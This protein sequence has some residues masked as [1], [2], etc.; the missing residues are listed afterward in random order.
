M[1][2]KLALDR[3]DVKVRSQACILYSQT[4]DAIHID[5]KHRPGH[6]Q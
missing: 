3:L 4:F 1:L 2:V 5:T 6:S